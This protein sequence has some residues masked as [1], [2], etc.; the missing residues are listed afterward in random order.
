MNLKW[1]FEAQGQMAFWYGSATGLVQAGLY[2][3]RDPQWSQ[4][5]VGWVSSEAIPSLIDLVKA[6]GDVL[7]HLAHGS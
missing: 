2:S 7:M 5:L 4:D 3:M 6:A 1:F